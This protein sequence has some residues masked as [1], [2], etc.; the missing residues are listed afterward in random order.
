MFTAK[1]D[2]RAP[3]DPNERE[4]T[5]KELA[6][7][8]RAARAVISDNQVLINEQ[9]AND[10]GLTS[11]KVVDA[12]KAGFEKAA[13]HP[14]ATDESSPL[15]QANESMLESIA[16]VMDKAQPLINDASKGFKGFLPA[17]FA[18]QVADGF[19][20]RMDGKFAIKLTAPKNLIRNM[21]NRPDEWENGVL[22]NKFKAKDWTRGAGFSENA[23][24]RGKPAY[25]L[26]IPE[27]YGASCLACHGEPKG[28]RDIT[29]GK[30]EGAKLD[31]LGGAISVV[32]YD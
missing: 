6:V 12:A 30:K 7:L 2:A 14:L 17:V 28:E 19:T 13:G 26:L 32:Q 8:F 22:E 27:Y 1:L 5:C 16:E 4:T 10:K 31:E 24:H 25:R 15:G 20:K 18:K 29:G 21:A 11:A 9:S 3:A 23:A